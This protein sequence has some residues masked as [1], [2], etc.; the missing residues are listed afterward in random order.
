MNTKKILLLGII[1]GILAVSSCTSIGPS[2][3][4]I[5]LPTGTLEITQSSTLAIT[6]LPT[7]PL[8]PTAAPSLAANWIPPVVS[9]SIE[10]VQHLERLHNLAEY[11]VT[12]AFSSDSKLL[13]S[14]SIERYTYIWNVH[15]GQLLQ[16]LKTQEDPGTIWSVTFSPDDTL[17]AVGS[18]DGKVR[19]WSVSDGALIRTLEGHTSDV[20]SVSFSPDGTQLVSGSN[21]QMI[22]LW[23]VSTGELLTTFQRNPGYVQSV[24]Y[25]PNGAYIVSGSGEGTIRLWDNNGKLLRQSVVAQNYISDVTFS[26]D[27]NW[28]AA[29]AE[30]TFLWIF[31]VPDLAVQQ[32]VKVSNGDI[33][34]VSF[35]SDG[36]ILLTG[37]EDH[38]ITF[39]QV[40]Q[41]ESGISV[42][43]LQDFDLE[44]DYTVNSVSISPDMKLAV[45]SSST[46][47]LLLWGVPA[48]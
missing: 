39:W 16:T 21:D 17:L 9:I 35:S 25:S 20:R 34:A 11:T 2:L 19:L 10:N 1:T 31:H 22:L 45:S 26:P 36:Q 46:G 6:P 38:A 18:G 48:P 41:A 3:T 29:G 30:N 24:R 28:I 40:D 23:E 5:P 8:T 47:D 7:N 27:S 33:N 32:A 13:A 37:D 4:P 42:S 44:R 14:G 43:L 15:N 12:T